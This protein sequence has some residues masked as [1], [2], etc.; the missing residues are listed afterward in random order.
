MKNWASRLFV[1]PGSDD[2]QLGFK[3]GKRLDAENLNELKEKLN[4]T[5]KPLG[6]TVN[7]A[8]RFNEPAC[9]KIPII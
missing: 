8:I 7:C 2:F 9:P 6:F 1:V 4:N 3:A 5:F